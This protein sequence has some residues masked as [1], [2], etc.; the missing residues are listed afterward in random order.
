MSDCNLGDI[1]HKV[2]V[3][4][5]QVQRLESRLFFG[6]PGEEALVTRIRILEAVA[7]EDRRKDRKVW[8]IVT[9]VVG[10]AAAILGSILTTWINLG[11]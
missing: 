5:Q 9:A 6:A 3:V 1:A 11:L 7:E 4:S 2:D 10:L 8:S